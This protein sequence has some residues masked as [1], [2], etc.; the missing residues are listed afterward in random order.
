MGIQRLPSSDTKGL[1]G[2]QKVVL[3][4]A[5]QSMFMAFALECVLYVCIPALPGSLLEMPHPGSAES[6]P[7]FG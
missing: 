6:E 3:G 1:G 5:V 7:A 2:P 4:L